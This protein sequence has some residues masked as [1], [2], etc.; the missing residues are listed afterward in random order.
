MPVT[1]S[2]EIAL[3]ADIEAEF[4]QTGTED[5]SLFQARTDAGLSSGEVAMTDFYGLS[6]SV[7]PSVSNYTVNAVNYQ[8]MRVYGNVTSDGGAPVTQRGFY[9][10]TSSNYANNPKYSVGSGTGIFNRYFTGLSGSTT[11]YY[12]SYAINSVGET[13]SATA[14]RSTSATPIFVYGNW[15]YSSG[16]SAGANLGPFSGTTYWGSWSARFTV[17][18]TT[19]PSN[20]YIPSNSPVICG[21]TANSFYGASYATANCKAVPTQI[22][23]G[24]VNQQVSTSSNIYF[25]GSVTTRPSGSHSYASAYISGNYVLSLTGSART[26]TIS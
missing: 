18:S 24:P 13:R 1:S 7:A 6:D 20:G 3:I 22:N 4:D 2:G 26:F 9:F 12:T 15:G 25:S 19:L 14:S 17:T 23:G 21:N 10:G 5:I 16:G 11:Y 8:Q